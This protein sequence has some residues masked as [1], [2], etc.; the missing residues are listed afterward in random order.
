M[1]VITRDLLAEQGFLDLDEGE[2]SE[3]GTYGPSGCPLTPEQI[4]THPEAKKFVMLDGDNIP[5]YEGFWVDATGNGN[6]FQ[7]L[8]DFGTPNAGCAYIR[9]V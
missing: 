7:P 2:T 9:Y 4:L 5:Y 3:A 1:W 8:D 6:S